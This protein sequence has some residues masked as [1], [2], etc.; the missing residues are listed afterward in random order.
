M[1]ISAKSC[2]S[3]SH[4]SMQ[5]ENLSGCIIPRSIKSWMKINKKLEIQRRVLL[6]LK[7]RLWCSVRWSFM[8]LHDVCLLVVTPC[9]LVQRFGGTWRQ[10]YKSTTQKTSTDIFIAV[11]TS[12]LTWPYTF[13]CDP[14]LWSWKVRARY[15]ICACISRTFLTRICPQKLGCG[16]YTE[17]YFLFTTEPATPVLYVAKLLVETASVWDLSCKLLHTRECTNLL[18]VYRHILITWE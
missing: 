3:E 11:R 5:H 1:N 4:I 17:Y 18:P 7:W 8:T 10:T 9:G 13:T 14:I 6:E 15:R 2:F 16:L 12:K